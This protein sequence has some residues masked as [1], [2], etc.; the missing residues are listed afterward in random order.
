M[1]LKNTGHSDLRDLPRGF[2]ASGT[3]QQQCC[4]KGCNRV[5]TK[6]VMVTTRNYGAEAFV[7]ETHAEL[8][9]DA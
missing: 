1:N 3:M 6:S 8:A 2:H 5:G 4:I 7:C 9:K